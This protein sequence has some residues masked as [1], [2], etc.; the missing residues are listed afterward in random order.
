MANTTLQDLHDL[1]D[2]AID[3]FEEKIQTYT[4]TGH[5]RYLNPEM[6]IDYWEGKDHRNPSWYANPRHYELGHKAYVASMT[7]RIGRD[8]ELDAAMLYKL[9]NG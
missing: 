2:K 5:R 1:A 6:M 7:W 4:T 9:T 3:A 8:E